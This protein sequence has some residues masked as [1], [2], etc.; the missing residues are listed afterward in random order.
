MIKKNHSFAVC[1]I[2]QNNKYYS[3]RLRKLY[4]NHIKE[5]D[6]HEKKKENE[7][8]FKLKTIP[9]AMYLQIDSIL[10]Q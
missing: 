9:L 2:K 5:K 10:S 1:H 7:E 6:N 3:Y 4:D 8:I